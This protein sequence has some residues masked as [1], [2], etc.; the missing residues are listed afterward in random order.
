[1]DVIQSLWVG[2][3]LSAMEQMCIKSFLRLGHPFHLYTYGAVVG[4]PEGAV[5]KDACDT[6]PSVNIRRFQNL[7]NFSDYFR[8]NLLYQQGGWWVDLD[9]YALRPFQFDSPY[10]FST[11]LVEARTG[12]EVNSGVIKM[13]KA[14]PM[15]RWCLDRI[16]NMDTLKTAW[17]EI[18]PALM[19]DGYRAFGLGRYV[20]PHRVFCPLHYFDAP[21]NVMG[22]GS[23]SVQFGPNTYSVHLWNEEA[24]RAGK[25]KDAAYSGDSLYERLRAEA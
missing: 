21:A 19:G 22:P 7:A 9:V 16:A 5:V 11:Q 15:M 4:V 20:Q 18:G 25:D 8:Y 13:P 14:A 3:R 2:D 17:S 6:A 1:M 23:G 10:V 24:R 12:D